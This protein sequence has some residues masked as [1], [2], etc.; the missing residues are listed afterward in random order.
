MGLGT[1][2][3]LYNT[4]LNCYLQIPDQDTARKAKPGDPFTFT[5]DA[6][7]TGWGEV[8]IDVV[9]DNKSIRRTFY[10]EEVRDRV[11]QV[12]TAAGSELNCST[13]RRRSPSHHS[14]AASTG[15]LFISMGWR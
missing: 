4:V 8:A 15:C 10:V 12:C 11:Y 7:K 9:Y 14:P 6:S 13:V 1:R 3:Q 5:V 2:Y